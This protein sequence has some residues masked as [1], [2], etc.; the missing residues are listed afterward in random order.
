MLDSRK[1]NFT[2]SHILFLSTLFA[3]VQIRLVYMYLCYVKNNIRVDGSEIKIT[4]NVKNYTGWTEQKNLRKA[5]DFWF[6]PIS[7]I[8]TNTHHTFSYKLNF[9]NELLQ[10]IMLHTSHLVCNVCYHGKYLW[11]FQINC[12]F[13][14]GHLKKNPRYSF[15]LPLPNVLYSP[16]I[17]SSLLY[18]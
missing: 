10:N 6:Y 9:T 14:C 15:T 11:Q 7:V 1:L 13:V 8:T 2:S 16:I 3:R 12:R 5:A 18:S 17:F 4:W